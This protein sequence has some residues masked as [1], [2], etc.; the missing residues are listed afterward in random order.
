MAMMK[1][2]REATTEDLPGLLQ[3]LANCLPYS[4]AMETQSVSVFWDVDQDDDQTV[5]ELLGS[6]PRLDWSE[7]VILFAVPIHLLHKVEQMVRCGE[8][9]NGRL[10][11]DPL[12]TAHL[13][14]ITASRLPITPRLAREFRLGAIEEHH[15]EHLYKHWKFSE[16]MTLE[17]YRR[18]LRTLPSVGVF[19]T[20]TAPANTTADET[21]QDKTLKNINLGKTTQES[22][23]CT[24]NGK[25][26][27]QNTLETTVTEDDASRETMISGGD[28]TGQSHTSDLPVAWTSLSY[29][30]YINNTFTL[31]EY[32]RR[33]LGRAVTLAL[34]ARVLEDDDRVL[35]YVVTDNDTSIKF[36]EELGFT[37]E[38]DFG[39]QRYSVL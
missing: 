6:T 30:N 20:D 13:Y 12:L 28:V 35:A 31:K 1:G 25:N 26:G 7:P 39:W 15:T 33:G 3:R 37:C 23:E 34:A 9:G 29:M 14:A 5:A 27:I 8:L 2:L 21:L 16:T 18:M 36:H 17:S 19:T 38:C 4:S 10:V 11:A 32:R 24:V 22:L